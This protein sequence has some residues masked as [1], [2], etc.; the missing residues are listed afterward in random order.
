MYF[1]NNRSSELIVLCYWPISWL[2]LCN[3]WIKFKREA[4]ECGSLVAFNL[5]KAYTAKIC[6]SQTEILLPPVMKSAFF[7]FLETSFKRY[8]MYSFQSKNMLSD[9]KLSNHEPLSIFSSSF[10]LDFL[11]IISVYIKI[12]SHIFFQYTGRRDLFCLFR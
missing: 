3:L 4:T 12:F 10:F 6:C 7:C 5:L 1:V 9:Q 8:W 2:R 11:C